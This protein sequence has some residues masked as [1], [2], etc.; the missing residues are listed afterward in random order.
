MRQ[1]R[2]KAYKRLMSLYSQF[3][4]FRSPFQVLGEL[5]VHRRP[6]DRNHS[7]TFNTPASP[8]ESDFLLDAC[9]KDLDIW[10]Q[11]ATCVQAECKPSEL[12]VRVWWIV[13][14]LFAYRLSCCSDH[15][16]LNGDAV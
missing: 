8:V 16:M 13:Q 12:S 6:L 14:L 4:G 11:L 2:A 10:K 5:V 9:K 15:A 1:K 3:F 7:P